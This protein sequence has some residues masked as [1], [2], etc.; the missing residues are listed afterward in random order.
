M[1]A[2]LGPRRAGVAPAARVLPSGARGSARAR[3]MRQPSGPAR[4]GAG[5]NGGEQAACGVPLPVPP[6]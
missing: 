6:A 3:T 2:L 4:E 1:P 5:V